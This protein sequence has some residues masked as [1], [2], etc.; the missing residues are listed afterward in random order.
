MSD[1]GKTMRVLAVALIFAAHA[2]LADTPVA[3]TA[4][5][6][7]S[8]TAPSQSVW[9]A[10]GD[11]YE[12]LQT[13]L[14]CPEKL[15]GYRRTSVDTFDR[16]GLDVGCN[17]TIGVAA[18]TF[19]LTRRDGQGGLEAAMTEAKAELLQAGAT[20]HAQL[21]S[22]TTSRKG[23]LDWTVALFSED[24]SLHSAIW[25]ADLFG[26][27]FEYRATYLVADEPRV[28][29]DIATITDAIRSSAGTRLQLCAKNP[30]PKRPGTAVT[31]ASQIQSAAM[32]SSI[33]GGAAQSAVEDHGGKPGQ[34][35]TVGEPVTWCVDK[36]ATQDGYPMVFWRGVNGDST[37]AMSDKVTVA[38][39]DRPTV[40]LDV[41][42][43]GLS[44][45]VEAVNKQDKKPEQWTASLQQGDQT[46]IFGYFAGRPSP[47]LVEDL[48]T[49]IL[50]GKAKPVGGYSAKG[51]TI[52]ILTPGK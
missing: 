18:V 36:T 29:A 5:N 20:R 46:L 4:P 52:T 40:T 44:D 35:F 6:T 8:L 38:T 31:D 41:S 51:K 11:S 1:W 19:Y 10:A 50:S 15:A 24:G 12:H 2:A 14:V 17:Y 3:A 45:L 25:I 13:G 43:G 9:R 16:Y 39:T 33:L 30:P 48:F 26:W 22:E 49:R 23:D 21:I 37:S 42:A 28:L 32:M 7:P 34:A 27:T 47:E